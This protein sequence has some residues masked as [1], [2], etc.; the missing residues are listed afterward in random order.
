VPTFVIIEQ[1][2]ELYN[3]DTGL[4]EI[5]DIRLIP[6]YDIIVEEVITDNPER[7]IHSSTLNMMA[8]ITYDQLG[9][10]PS[11]PYYW[12]AH[13]DQAKWTIF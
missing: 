4:Y 10:S 3:Y 1:T 12:Y 13:L 7:F 8:R 9:P 6:N 2:I 5:I 11:F